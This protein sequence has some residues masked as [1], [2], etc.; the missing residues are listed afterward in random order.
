MRLNIPYDSFGLILWT[1]TYK[2]ALINQETY[3]SPC[4]NTRCPYSVLESRLHVPHH[5][6]FGAPRAKRSDAHLDLCPDWIR[7]AGTIPYL[8]L[9]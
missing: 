1:A 8:P 5:L 4:D 6:I 2:L 7:G 3:H 9:I